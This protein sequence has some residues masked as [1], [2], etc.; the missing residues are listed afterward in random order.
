MSFHRFGYS[1]EK[2]QKDKIEKLEKELQSQ[3]KLIN[4]NL[5][6]ISDKLEKSDTRSASGKLENIQ[7]INFDDRKTQ[8][9]QCTVILRYK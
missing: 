4:L 5:N 6:D 2:L 3:T 1:V 7:D 8:G 9:S